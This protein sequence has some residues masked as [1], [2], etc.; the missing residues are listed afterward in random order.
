[1]E[2]KIP[3]NELLKKQRT[4]RIFLIGYHEYIRNFEKFWFY[5]REASSD[6]PRTVIPFSIKRDAVMPCPAVRVPV[7]VPS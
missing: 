6:S 5:G 4:R 1:M 2:K 7:K 3:V